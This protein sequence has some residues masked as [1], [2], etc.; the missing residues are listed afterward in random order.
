MKQM[1][2]RKKLKKLV[3]KSLRHPWVLWGRKEYVFILSHMRSR[4]TLLSHILG[5]HPRICGYAEMHQSYETPVDLLWLRHQLQQRGEKSPVG[6][7]ALDKMLHDAQILSPSICDHP[8][9]KKIFLLR[10]P[11]EAVK[12][13]IHMGHTLKNVAWHTDPVAVFSYYNQRLQTLGNYAKRTKIPGFFIESGDM[14]QRPGRLLEALSAWLDLEAKLQSTYS[15]FRYTGQE[16]HGD[17]SANIKA[18]KILSQKS[19][20]TTIVLDENLLSAAHENYLSTCETMQRH[21]VTADSLPFQH[22]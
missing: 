22:V 21:C 2:Y 17:P 3:C 18:G 16:K 11:A 4:S 5:S 19:D 8:H 9:I 15:T 14:I 10:P 20:Y 6:R 1:K 7:F 13:I 12:S